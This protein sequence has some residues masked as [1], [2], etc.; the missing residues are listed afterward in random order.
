MYLNDCLDGCGTE[1]SE[2]RSMKLSMSVFH[3][4]K[5]VLSKFMNCSLL[6]FWF[7]A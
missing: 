5:Q 7:I 6:I 3:G 4:L 1:I 2:D